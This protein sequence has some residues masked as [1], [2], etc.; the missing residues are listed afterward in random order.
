MNSGRVLLLVP[1]LIVLAASIVLAQST[2]T[3][4][5]VRPRRP[6]PAPSAAATTGMSNGDVIKMVRA[7]LS[8]DIIVTAIQAA[9]QKSFDVTADGLIQLKTAGVSD[10]V[11]SAIQGK[12]IP[13]SPTAAAPAMSAPAPS[14]AASPVSTPV[15]DI[16]AEIRRPHEPGIYAAIKGTLVQLSSTP[17]TGGGVGA[18]SLLK[19]GFTMGLKKVQVKAEVRG[20]QADMR[21]AP[22]VEFYFLGNGYNANDF[23]IAR[24]EP[25]D[26]K[27][28]VVVGAAGMLGAKSGLREE[29][30][31]D[32][33]PTKID[34][35][36]FKVV[37]SRDL[38]PGEYGFV[39]LADEKDRRV[40]DFGVDR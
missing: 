15:S 10:R 36:I 24:L 37:P 28:Q 21:V 14:A 5:P 7:G 18:G 20:S 38:R 32:A 25:G 35:G 8:D 23:A 1:A 31:I 11:I 2:A 29:D 9:A 39:N 4:A 3:P 27:R 6:S 34:T 30:Q 17:V 40:W 22:E 33:R 26:S 12:L 19:S 13:P 16:N